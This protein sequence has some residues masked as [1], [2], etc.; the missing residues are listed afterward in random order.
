[1]NDS[2]PLE[3]VPDFY[4]NYAYEDGNSNILFTGKTTQLMSQIS[5]TLPVVY[6]GKMVYTGLQKSIEKIAV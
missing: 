1:M 2:N 6:T 3:I 4:T 5:V